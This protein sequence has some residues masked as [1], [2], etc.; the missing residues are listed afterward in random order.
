MVL[1]CKHGVV[2]AM[3]ETFNRKPFI[4]LTGGSVPAW[5]LF[6]SE[7]GIKT[8]PFAFGRPDDNVHAPNERCA[9]CSM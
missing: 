5:A 4:F 6:E 3:E 2:K 8:T 7:L 9:L 1:R